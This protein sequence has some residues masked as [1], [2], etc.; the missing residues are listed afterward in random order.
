MG[1]PPA[2]EHISTPMKQRV[3][4]TWKRFYDALKLLLVIAKVSY[5]HPYVCS[6]YIE[7]SKYIE[8]SSDSTGTTGM[9]AIKVTA[10]GRPNLLVCI[11]RWLLLV[12]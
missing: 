2:L 9:A 12:F 6:P 11:K 5:L 10:L 8:F 4:R 7:F 3:K 1:I